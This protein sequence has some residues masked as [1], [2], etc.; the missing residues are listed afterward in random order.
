MHEALWVVIIVV[1]IIVLWYVLDALHILSL[2]FTSTRN[3]K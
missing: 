3:K 2:F 1:G